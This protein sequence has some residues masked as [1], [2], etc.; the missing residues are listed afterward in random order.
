MAC[1]EKN[2]RSLAAVEIDSE[3][4]FKY[5]L[6][7][8]ESDTGEKRNIVRG[9]ASAECHTNLFEKLCPEMEEQG[10]VCTCLGGGKIEH[11]SKDKKIHVFG[12]STGCG[13]AD[14]NVTVELLKSV[15]QDYEISCSDDRR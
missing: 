13:K 7:R 14:H 3:G 6:V 15:F 8:V 10:F 11:N 2:L 12:L 5:I 1:P 9:S 4:T